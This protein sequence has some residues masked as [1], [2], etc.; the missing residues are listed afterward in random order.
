MP[1]RATTLRRRG[2]RL[3]A[4][5]REISC[6]SA[7]IE[8]LPPIA[9]CVRGLNRVQPFHRP[10]LI[11][12]FVFDVPDRVRPFCSEFAVTFI[13]CTC[14]KSGIQGRTDGREAKAS[15]NRD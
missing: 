10:R 2:A 7:Q 1:L 15:A 14:A 4:G 12:A 3:R 11:P 9:S 8:R 5:T 13:I 6:R